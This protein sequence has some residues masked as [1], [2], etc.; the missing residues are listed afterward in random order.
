LA[1]EVS[2]CMPAYIAKRVQNSLNF[3]SKTVK[4]SNIL[5]L[6]VAY[7]PNVSDKRQTPAIPLTD[8]L[9]D[10]GAKVSFYDPYVENFFVEEVE[11]EREE[12]L[13]NGLTNCDLAILLTAHNDII[14]AEELRIA[15]IIF[16]TRGVLSGENVENL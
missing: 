7:K 14:E 3:A 11:I 1:Q 9:L 6:G 4:G 5:L 16:D 8:H 10:M 13:K 2:E 15:S 12:S